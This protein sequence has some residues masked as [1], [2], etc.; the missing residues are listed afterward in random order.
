MTVD[1]LMNK[2]IGNVTEVVVVLGKRLVNSHLTEE[3]RSRIE[4]LAKV[5]P[6]LATRN[7]V[8]IF[9]GG[10]LE[11]QYI[12]EAQAMVDYLDEQFLEDAECLIDSQ[13]LIEDQS[14]TSVENFS[15]ACS[16][17]IKSKLCVTD[18]PVNVRL[19]SNEYHIERII[20]IEQLMPEQGLLNGLKKNAEKVGLILNVSLDITQHITAAYPHKTL[21][22]E[23][24]LLVD[25]LTIYRVYLEG[26]AGDVFRRSLSEVREQP[27]MISVV[28]LEQLLTMEI[29]LQHLNTLLRLRAIIEQ[30]PASISVHRLIPLLAEFNQLLLVLNRGIDPEGA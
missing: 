22:G 2:T 8:M 19:V 23:A 16:E 10:K 6:S 14:T 28:A 27:Y 15:N 30:T 29:A 21:C 7:R 3:G 9:C 4:V 20:K 18:I 17:L 26:V 12:S 13:I 11:N 1:L 24:F 25:Q 5:L